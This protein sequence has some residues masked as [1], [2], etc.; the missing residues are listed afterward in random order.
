MSSTSTKA[1]VVPIPG[2][3]AD[4]A[5]LKKIIESAGCVLVCAAEKLDEFDTCLRAAD[6]V[7]VLICPE[8][9]DDR[10]IGHIVVL[11]NKFG[12]RVVGVWSADADESKLPQ[13]LHRYADSVVRIAETEMGE[14]ICGGEV[15]WLTPKGEPFPTPR[16]PR[17]KGH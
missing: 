13:T 16:T 9:Y 14:S 11:A 17:H 10:L 6:V 8:T 1:Y 12:K 2:R 7:V 15:K 4:I 5:A 3:D